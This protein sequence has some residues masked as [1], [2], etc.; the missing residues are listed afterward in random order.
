MNTQL[1][2]PMDLEEYTHT[3]EMMVQSRYG[4]RTRLSEEWEEARK[5]LKK[6]TT[7][8]D[9]SPN[10]NRQRFELMESQARMAY[11]MGYL[12]QSNRILQ[13]QVNMLSSYHQRL[14]IL[15]GAYGHLMAM[16]QSVKLEYY[17]KLKKTVEREK[18]NG[19]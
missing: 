19:E 14:G 8:P 16:T 1:S 6:N 4:D 5:I 9:G 15:E 2:H 10:P 11:D 12:L 3:D 13:D 18:K 17:A 7:L